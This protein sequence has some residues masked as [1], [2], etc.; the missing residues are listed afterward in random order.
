MG[1]VWSLHGRD[2]NANKIVERTEGRD[3][4]E[5][6]VI[7]AGEYLNGYYRNRVG[8]CGLDACDSE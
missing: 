1:E 8:K 6:I 2:K 7:D 5:D 3:H 4:A